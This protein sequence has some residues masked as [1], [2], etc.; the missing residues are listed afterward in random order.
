M[1]RT[2]F[3]LFVFLLS[4]C[5][6]AVAEVDAT[7]DLLPR[8]SPSANDVN[9][10]LCQNYALVA[11]LSTVALNSTYR[12]AFLRSSP[13]GTFPARAILDVESPKLPAMMMDAQLN[14]R[15]GNLS[16]VALAGAAANLSAGTV[17][18]LPILEAPG[19]D[20]ANVAMPIVGIAIFLMFGGTWL[21][22]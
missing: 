14:Q 17:L 19:I 7:H 8:Q 20:P 3:Q 21:A 4:I 5:N 11:N 1:F 6:I 12:A 2:P 16:E 9:S 13:L 18:G 15:C 10:P 22:L